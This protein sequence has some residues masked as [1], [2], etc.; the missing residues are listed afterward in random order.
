M[1]R[2]VKIAGRFVWHDDPQPEFASMGRPRPVDIR[3]TARSTLR[4]TVAELQA[5]LDETN[6]ALVEHE[7]R[8][9]EREFARINAGPVGPT[10]AE[11]K[12]KLER[13]GSVCSALPFMASK[14]T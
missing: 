3:H 8:A 6:A 5:R 7:R 14:F 13:K 1:G 10:Q 4:P 12:R 11:F 9:T 2:Y